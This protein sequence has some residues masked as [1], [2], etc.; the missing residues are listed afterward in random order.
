M[1][2]KDISIHDAVQVNKAMQV[3]GLM[4]ENPRMSQAQACSQI[5]INPKTYRKWIATQEDAIA[6]IEK[7]R[8]EIEKIELASILAS[9][10]AV[11]ENFIQEAMKPGISITERIK[12]LEYID[13]RLDEL[14]SRY[15]VVDVEAEQD[16]LSG[17]KQKP[18]INKLANRGTKE[19]KEDSLSNDRENEET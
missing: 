16:L 1:D 12:A 9:K 2:T 18:G 11:T 13:K 5:G 19:E 3:Y 8:Q 15:H 14:S 4:I 6:E 17:P 10:S 7:I